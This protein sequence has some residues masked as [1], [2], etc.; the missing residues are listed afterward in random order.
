MI[1]KSFLCFLNENLVNNSP[2][3]SISVLS[4]SANQQNAK[5]INLVEMYFTPNCMAYQ[6]ELFKLYNHS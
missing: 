6:R 4:T 3:S 5:R 1:S 2:F